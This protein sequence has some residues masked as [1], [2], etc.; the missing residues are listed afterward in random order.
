MI[1]GKKWRGHGVR[2]AEKERTQRRMQG[3][4]LLNVAEMSNKVRS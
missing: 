2:E 4:T 1:A 3:P